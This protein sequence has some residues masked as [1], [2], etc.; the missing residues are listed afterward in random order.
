MIA[1]NRKI[2]DR[3]SSLS[4]FHRFDYGPNC[5]FFVWADRCIELCKAN[6]MYIEIT[7]II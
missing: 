7:N 6:Y 3:K 4:E 2:S 5:F 1:Y